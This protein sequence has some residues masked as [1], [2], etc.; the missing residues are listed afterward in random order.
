MQ[1]TQDLT[2]PQ[3]LGREINP[4]VYPAE[5]FRQKLA[6]GHRFV[7]SVADG[8]KM[9]VVGDEREFARLGS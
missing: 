7:S 4:T 9:F 2:L 5:E 8:P 3:K 1:F 6:D